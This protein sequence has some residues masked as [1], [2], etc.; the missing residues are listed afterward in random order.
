MPQNSKKLSLITATKHTQIQTAMQPVGS[1][2][3]DMSIDQITEET[4]TLLS[5]YGNYAD[6][7]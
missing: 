4:E 5:Q 1:Y 7:C 2:S 3:T 6:D